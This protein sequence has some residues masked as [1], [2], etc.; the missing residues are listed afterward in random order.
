M[1]PSC[2]ERHRIEL[3]QIL[4]S[5]WKENLES[6]F[7]KAL[8]IEAGDAIPVIIS[9]NISSDKIQLGEKLCR[10]NNKGI[11]VVPHEMGEISSVH[12]DCFQFIEREVY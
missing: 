1:H 2:N 5:E 4:A 6:D 12:S 9:K 3:E 10:E 7:E 8:Q 11:W